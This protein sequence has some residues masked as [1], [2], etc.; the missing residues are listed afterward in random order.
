[1]W[2]RLCNTFFPMKCNHQQHCT[3]NPP[4]NSSE[5]TKQCLGDRYFPEIAECSSS[6]FVP[7]VVALITSWKVFKTFSNYKTSCISSKR[8]VARKAGSG[9]HMVLVSRLKE[10]LRQ[11]RQTKALMLPWL[12]SSS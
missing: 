10:S 3:A 4:P 6:S 8:T 5:Y 7:A 11:A 9:Q 2:F 12:G 1:M